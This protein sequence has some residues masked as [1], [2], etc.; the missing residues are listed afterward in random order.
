MQKRRSANILNLS[1][2]PV[3]V[4]DKDYHGSLNKVNNLVEFS[5]KTARIRNVS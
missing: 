3:L 5:F 1:L 2:R 4:I